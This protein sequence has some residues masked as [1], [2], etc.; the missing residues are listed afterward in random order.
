MQKG[1][2]KTGMLCRRLV[3]N[4][5]F[6]VFLVFRSSFVP[7]HLLP[8][9]PL[10]LLCF[11]TSSHCRLEGTPAYLPPEILTKR[12]RLPGFAAD[13]WALGCVAYFCLHGR[14]KFFGDNEQVGEAVKKLTCMPCC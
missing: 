9:F 10:L 7:F 6:L 12:V 8:R 1:R 2:R 14:P 4:P 13:A 11:C 5:D 3:F